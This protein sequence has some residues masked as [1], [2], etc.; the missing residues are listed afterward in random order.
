MIL[1]ILCMKQ[2][3]GRNELRTLEYFHFHLNYHLYK[4]LMT[5]NKKVKNNLLYKIK[6][7]TSKKL[8]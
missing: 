3:Q 7:K 5:Y 2:Y 4:K 1:K 8:L 6:Y